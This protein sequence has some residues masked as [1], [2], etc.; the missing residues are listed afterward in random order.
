MAQYGSLRRSSAHK[1]LARLSTSW[2]RGH[3]LSRPVIQQ[4]L[5]NNISLR[6]ELTSAA[7]LF[8]TLHPFT[9]LLC[10]SATLNKS[11][12]FVIGHRVFCSIGKIEKKRRRIKVRL[13][14]LASFFT[15]GGSRMSRM[16]STSSRSN[17]RFYF[18]FILYLFQGAILYSCL[19]LHHQPMMRNS[20]CKEVIL[21]NCIFQT[22]RLLAAWS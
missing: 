19:T 4:T 14:F 21:E 18:F 11:Y 5:Q 3:S 22:F 17:S 7:F 16:A 2:T 13:L 8:T 1:V 9:I 15:Q 12:D 10:W 6:K 20:W